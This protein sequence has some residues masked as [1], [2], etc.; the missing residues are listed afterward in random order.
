[1]RHKQTMARGCERTVWLCLAAWAL[2]ACD[3]SV[4]L[5]GELFP[6]KTQ[7]DCDGDHLCLDDPAAPAPFTKA[8]HVA[9]WSAPADAISDSQVPD[10]AGDSVD[11]DA[12]VADMDAGVDV[13][14]G[15]G[16]D[17]GPDACLDA[18]CPC[19]DGGSCGAGLACLPQ[20]GKN[21]TCVDL[22]TT[23]CMPCGKDDDCAITGLGTGATCLGYGAAGSFC[24]AECSAGPCPDGFTCETQAGGGK[25]C[26]AS[27][28]TCE[29]RC[30]AYA[31]EHLN[32]TACSNGP[33]QGKRACTVGKLTACDAPSAVTE[34]AC[35]GVDDDCN[36]MANDVPA[37]CAIDAFKPTGGSGSGCSQDGECPAG[38]G[39]DAAKGKCRTLIGKCPGK[40]SCNGGVV[41]CD[42]KTPTPETCN[43]SDE[44][45][46]GLIDEDF[47]YTAPDGV[48][49]TYGSDCGT[50]ACKGGSVVC[51]NTG[52]KAICTLDGQ[53]TAETCNGLDDDCDGL[54]DETFA[55]LGKACDGADTDL[56]ANGKWGCSLD[57]TGVTCGIETVQ[58][59]AEVCN[60]SDD[61]CDGKT[62]EDL[63]VGLACDGTDTDLC[64]HGVKVCDGQGGVLCGAESTK[65]IA[66][67][68][69][70][71][72]DDCDG[73]TDE[74]LGLGT[75]CDGPD[76]DK[77]ANG[78]LVCDGKGGVTCGTE[79]KVDLVEMCNGVDDDC[80][81]MTDEGCV[82][83]D[84][85]G[86]CATGI[87]VVPGN[88]ICAKGGSD[89]NDSNATV[90]LG[91]T[92]ACNG[93][94]DDCDG[95]TDNPV[96]NTSGELTQAC[97]SGPGSAKGVG[98][99]ALGVQTCAGGVFSVCVGSVLPQASD[100]CGNGADDNCDGQTDEG[101][102][103]A[104]SIGPGSYAIGCSG[105][106]GLTCG[107]GESPEFPF[108]DQEF[109]LGVYEVSVA[110]YAACVQSG[111]CTA[112]KTGTGCNWGVAG[113]GGHPVNC[114]TWAQARSYCQ[115]Q[116]GDLPNEF[117]WEAANDGSPCA[118][119]GSPPPNPCIPSGG[120]QQVYIWG[121]QAPSCSVGAAN[122]AN[123]TV[124]GIGGTVAVSGVPQ[125]TSK[126]VNMA[127][128]V[129]EWT[130]SSYVSYP[131][132][133]PG[134]TGGSFISVRGG[135]YASS[136]LGSRKFTREKVDATSA[137]PTIGFRCILP[138]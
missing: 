111:F 23:L 6:C 14:S 52:T 22:A 38:E 87:N 83:A 65:D 76:S 81:G 60:G 77:C 8:C 18:G 64:A 138:L 27:Q 127:G 98:E 118:A 119:L 72:D 85:D 15:A 51:N 53:I 24:G 30:P 134:S 33:C 37:T 114:V 54:T 133:P 28:G 103:T 63:G 131:Q 89:C 84:G 34:V 101:C 122:Y 4:S 91:G 9:G 90:N 96:K 10:S 70:G 59:I 47:V 1:M 135:S 79:A 71:I 95:G 109:N 49:G 121:S 100:A 31:S 74:G 93:V 7:A 102:V 46:D 136:E 43:G 123:T 88:S 11:V 26:R 94:D 137:L 120:S 112:P 21:P 130:L 99:C 106:S 115:A 107:S 41:V 40:A 80:D 44:D 69:N 25:Q 5:Q 104:V 2:A 13:D 97:Y 110:S 50:G 3:S 126:L 78:K 12:T 39:C 92:E 61:D 45:C 16:T 36:G 32:S 58:D 129:A 113:K 73:Q 57:K 48:T 125:G 124:C 29:G 105:Q 117:Q 17:S 82:D 62:D 75:A 116:G 66:E 132:N 67:V 68:C 35:N 56:C 19:G 42:G 86:Y 55:T 108:P 20:G 128:N